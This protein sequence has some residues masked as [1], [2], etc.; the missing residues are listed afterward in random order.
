MAGTATVLA[1]GLATPGGAGL[2]LAAQRVRAL[3]DG[4]ARAL[5]AT[6]CRQRGCEV[7]VKHSASVFR[8]VVL[9]WVQD[10]V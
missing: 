2:A 3:G 10:P 4:T 9:L 7:G 1:H 8:S 5:T 6:F